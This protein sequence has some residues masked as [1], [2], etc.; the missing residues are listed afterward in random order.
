M[1]LTRIKSLWMGVE[2][3][4][5]YLEG[6]S[7]GDF[8]YGTAEFKFQKDRFSKRNSAQILFAKK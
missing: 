5:L 4:Y 1:K 3:I 7:L 8:C 6:E 2:V